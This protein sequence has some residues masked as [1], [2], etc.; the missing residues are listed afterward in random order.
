MLVFHFIFDFLW[1]GRISSITSVVF[2]GLRELKENENRH[3]TP[4]P[5]SIPIHNNPVGLSMETWLAN[6]WDR[7]VRSIEQGNDL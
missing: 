4:F 3:C 7:H 2:V 6:T 1:R 5:S